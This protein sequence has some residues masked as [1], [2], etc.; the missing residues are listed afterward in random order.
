MASGYC[1]FKAIVNLFS[2]GKKRILILYE[3][4]HYITPNKKS[5]HFSFYFTVG[6]EGVFFFLRRLICTRNSKRINSIMA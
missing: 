4:N 3:N 1:A 5:K 2:Y 6:D